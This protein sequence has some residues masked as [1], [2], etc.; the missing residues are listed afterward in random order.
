MTE[1]GKMILEDEIAKE[2]AKGRAEGKIEGKAELLL[3]LLIKKFKKMPEGYRKKI[4]ELPDEALEVVALEIFDMKD[5]KEVE[6][7]F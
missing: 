7:Y 3:K 1:I 5:I 4:K 2:R 6:E